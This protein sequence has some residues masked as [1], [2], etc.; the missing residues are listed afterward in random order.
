MHCLVRLLVPPWLPPHAQGGVGKLPL[1][2][3]DKNSPTLNRVIADRNHT[4]VTLRKSTA[5]LSLRNFVEAVTRGAAAGGRKHKAKHWE[6]N[7]FVALLYKR[8]GSRTGL[9]HK[10][11]VP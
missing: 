3:G 5:K 1:V 6:R 2:G 4:A 11:P 10:Q 8:D 9:T 7:R